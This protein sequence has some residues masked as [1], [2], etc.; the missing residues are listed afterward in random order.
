MAARNIRV[1]DPQTGEVKRQVVQ[2]SFEA[3]NA[4]ELQPRQ[5]V[6]D[7]ENISSLTISILPP[8]FT[9]NITLTTVFDATKSEIR[10]KNGEM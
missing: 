1:S 9:D 8:N 7:T 3:V 4:G 6:I 5:V 2:T 10:G